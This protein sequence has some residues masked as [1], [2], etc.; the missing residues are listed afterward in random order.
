VQKAFYIRGKETAKSLEIFD[1]GKK[2][3]S[4]K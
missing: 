3:R 4:L 1:S 2:K